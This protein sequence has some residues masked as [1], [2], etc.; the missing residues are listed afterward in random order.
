MM[1]PLRL[2]ARAELSRMSFEMARDVLVKLTITPRWRLLRR[3]ALFMRASDLVSDG[4][5][6][7]SEAA[8]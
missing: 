3:A 1:G 6:F 4:M 7:Q 8:G 2:E 5:H